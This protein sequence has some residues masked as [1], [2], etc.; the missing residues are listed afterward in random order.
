M[1][2]LPHNFAEFRSQTYW[3]G[4]FRKRN[5]IPFEWYG[6]WQQLS[7]FVRPMC[8]GEQSEK[9]K[10]VLIVGCG[11]SELSA[12]MYDGGI[13]KITNIDFSKICI[14]EMLKKN[15]RARPKMRWLVMDMTAM[16]FP[17]ASFDVVVDKG[18]LDALMGEP[19]EDAEASGGKLLSEVC[20]VV[21]PHGGCYVCVTLAQEHVLDLLL[22]KLRSGWSVDIFRVP[23]VVTGNMIP[24]PLHTFVVVATSDPACFKPSITLGFPREYS[25]GGN[26]TSLGQAQCLLIHE[27]LLQ[28]VD[29]MLALSKDIVVEDFERLVPGR[30]LVRDLT[31]DQLTGALNPKSARRLSAKRAVKTGQSTQRKS[32]RYTAVILDA[33]DVD[34][35]ARPA[36]GCAVFLV[37]QGREHE[38]LFSSVEGQ[39]QLLEQTGMARLILVALNRGHQF[40]DLAQVQAELSPL[41]LRLVPEKYRNSDIPIPYL[42]T[43][44]GIGHRIVLEEVESALSGRITVE[45]VE[46]RSSMTTS[47]SNGSHGDP[48]MFRRMVFARNP[49]LIQSE[50]VLVPLSSYEPVAA[51]TTGTRVPGRHTATTAA[52]KK[53][54]LAAGL[55]GLSLNERLV[56]HSQLASDY[57]QAMIAGLSLV[58]SGLEERIASGLPIQAVVVGLGGGALP[59]FLLRHFPF[60]IQVAELD[61]VVIDMAVRHFGV[62]QSSR[63]Q[64]TV[65]DGVAAV[66]AIAIA[67]SVDSDT[68][69]NEDPRLTDTTQALLDIIVVD[70]DSGDAR[71]VANSLAFIRLGCLNC[72]GRTSDI[73]LHSLC[74]SGMSCPPPEF[75]A[76]PFLQTAKTVLTETG[77]LMINTCARSNSSYEAALEAVLE[78]FPAVYTASMEG[79]VNRVLFALPIK[80]MQPNAKPAALA[81]RLE[82]LA[83]SHAPW[84]KTLNLVKLVETLTPAKRREAQMTSSS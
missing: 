31:E 60:D 32:S 71:Q 45:D 59:M 28:A 47:S 70:A 38:W 11:N 7:A 36:P 49:N 10:E 54:D 3:D 23:P 2:L 13:E 39:W 30:R 56:D 58:A 83:S 63:L 77:V 21:K 68:G 67:A 72:L 43:D 78:V 33:S 12:E 41:V 1:D 14:M 61:P 19:G 81:E 25:A 66:S 22:W 82:S 75:V 34:P 18:G 69:S 57:H 26:A 55:A 17:D 15:V 35:N 80:P 53:L 16:Q 8:A 64:V 37:P 52:K 48:G 50:A 62:R 9:E 84:V 20:R 24:S 44:S 65:Q 79:D 74:S 46:L 40:G 5:S 73:C 29:K 76:L 51:R 42:T 4:F 6:D 27:G